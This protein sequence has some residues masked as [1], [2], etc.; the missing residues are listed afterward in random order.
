MLSSTSAL[1]SVTK[2]SRASKTASPPPS[3]AAL[4]VPGFGGVVTIMYAIAKAMI[5]CAI[6]W[7]PVFAFQEY[8]TARLCGASHERGSPLL[9][10]LTRAGARA[11]LYSAAGGS[12][13]T[14]G[15][16]SPAAAWVKEATAGVLDGKAVPPTDPAW[17]TPSASGAPATSLYQHIQRKHWNV[18]FLRYYEL[19]QIPNFLLASPIAFLTYFGLCNYARFW[20]P[21]LLTRS[22]GRGGRVVAGGGTGGGVLG[23]VANGLARLVRAHDQRPRGAVGDVGILGVGAMPFMLMWG[24]LTV[25]YVLVI[26]VQVVTR[27]LL[28]SCPPAVWWLA[29]AWGSW[30]GRRRQFLV[31]YMVVFNV[32]G[33]AMHV[34]FLPWT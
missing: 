32:V 17:C 9:D 12:S 28:A 4:G 1:V 2:E 30:S 3:A 23:S 6:I 7:A 5:C 29:E 19:K 16:T 31:A 24:V 11:G 27:L 15:G 21:R 22:K 34:N 33:V 20:G 18:G 10:G 8:G 26:N 25:M 13:H 14:P